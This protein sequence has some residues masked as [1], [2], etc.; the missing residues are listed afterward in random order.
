MG[1][2]RLKLFGDRQ[3]RFGDAV[4]EISIGSFSE[5]FGVVTHYWAPRQY[6]EQWVSALG[7]LASGA[8]KGAIIASIDDPAIPGGRAWIW[9]F[10]RDGEDVVFQNILLFLDECAPAFSP[11]DPLPCVPDRETV[12]EDGEPISE[13]RVPLTG[14]ETSVEVH[15]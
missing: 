6:E 10:Y 5:E 9:A 12:S 8:V 7:Q 14:L 11:T 4:G 15:E 3:T 2:L 13:W 1:H